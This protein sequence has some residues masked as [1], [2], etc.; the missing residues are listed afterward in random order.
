MNRREFSKYMAVAGL[1]PAAGRS[2]APPLA[3]PTPEQRTWQDMELETFVHFGPLTWRPN[4]SD[5]TLTPASQMNPEKLDTEQWAD[6]AQSMGSKQLVFVAKHAAGFCWWQTDTTTYGVKQSPWRG[7]K[8]DV[9]QDLSASCRKRGMKLGVYLSPADQF[10]QIRVAGRA[11]DEAAQQ[12]YN[13]IYRQQLTELL[14]R[15]GE[16]SE[17]WCDGS[18]VVDIGDILKRYMPKAMV[19]QSKYATIRWVGNE[20]GFAPDP[21]WNTVSAEAARSGVATA[22]DGD[23][24]GAVWLPN[25]IDTRL[26]AGWFWSPTNENTL[27]SLDELMGIYY[28]SVGH[29]AVL[30]MNQTP[31]RSGLIPEPDVRRTAEFGAEIRK[32]FGKPVA[33]TSGKGQ[34]VELSLKGPQRIDHV[35]T[36]EDIAQGQRVREYRVDGLIGGEWKELVRGTSIGQKKIDVVRPVE[37]SK[38]RWTAMAAAAPPVIRRL[39]V[40]DAGGQAGTAAMRAA[41]PA[42]RTIKQWDTAGLPTEWTRWDIDLA[43]YCTEAGQYE[44]AFFTTGGSGGITVQSVT[45]VTAGVEA[46][47][48]VTPAP[49]RGRTYNL[50]LTGIEPDM[51]L[52]VVVRRRGD[53]A[54]GQIV[55]KSQ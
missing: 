24:N 21:N 2:A 40:Y 7:G 5:R 30:L 16:I 43:P 11:A 1:A 27:K 3:F 15:Y 39:A 17:V 34:K 28:R 33:E 13:A 23:P 20:E 44:V 49:G 45:L 19:F 37:V 32:R 22:K 9:M 10:L 14:T 25:E 35:V 55:L 42:Y 46:P 50:N 53:E 29:G 51:K 41:T 38:I 47:E 26:R 31:D 48:F 8:G 54:F 12:K 6:V 36:M 4:E 18:L 52:R